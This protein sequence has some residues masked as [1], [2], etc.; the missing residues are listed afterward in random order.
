MSPRMRFTD[1]VQYFEAVS[2]SKQP[3]SIMTGIMFPVRKPSFHLPAAMPA[4]KQQNCTPFEQS[5]STLAVILDASHPT[6]R[7]ASIME[8]RCP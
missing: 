6:F 2:F 7:P 3:V 5:P 8:L 4:A 1:V